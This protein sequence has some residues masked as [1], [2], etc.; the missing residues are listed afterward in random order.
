MFLIPLPSATRTMYSTL[1]PLHNVLRWL[2]A[3]VLLLVLCRAFQGYRSGAPFT[4][5]DDNL[6]HWT[7][8]IVHIQ[9]AV[10]F[11]LYFSS[12]VVKFF[13]SD[14]MRNLTLREFSFFGMTHICLMLIAVVVITLGS[15]M[16]K[17]KTTDKDKFK[18]ML[19]WY[20]IGL[21]IIFIAVPWPF[22]P[23]A[24]RPYLRPF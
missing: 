1:L 21:I 23:F 10:G 11:T 13:W 17:R 6:R 16:A 7:A 2:V 22:S 20:A 24:N 4:K 8:T 19:T 9:F 15:A 3:G 18:T 14:V 12:P 5:A